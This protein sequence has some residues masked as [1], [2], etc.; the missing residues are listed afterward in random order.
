[1]DKPSV[2]NRPLSRPKVLVLGNGILR[3]FG[4][5][6]MGCQDLEALICK[7]AGV[8][9]LMD[10]ENLK[11]EEISLI[12]FSMRLAASLLKKRNQEKKL[13]TVVKDLIFK[14]KMG[15]TTANELLCN[16]GIIGVRPFTDLL[17]ASYDLS[18]ANLTVAV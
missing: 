4:N 15:E 2:T 9:P 7:M 13:E 5:G 8:K 17:E 18:P 3:A 1:M 11:N 6:A 16:S 14:K 10:V 12:P